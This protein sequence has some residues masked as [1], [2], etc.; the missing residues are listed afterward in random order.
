[1]LAIIDGDTLAYKSCPGRAKFNPN[2]ERIITLNEAGEK[3]E[4]YTEE[5]NAKY[6]SVVWDNFINGLGRMLSKCVAKDFVMAIKG[7]DNFRFKIYDDYKKHRTAKPSPNFPIVTI[8]RDLCVQHGMAI[9]AHG[10]EADDYIRIWANEARAA[11]Q[12]YI[13][14]TGDK[15]LRCIPGNH[16][17]ILNLQDF[18]IDEVSE[19]DAKRNYYAQLLSGDPTDWI[20]GLKGVADI[21]AR[22]MIADCRTEA[23]LQERVIAAYVTHYQ[24]DWANMLLTNGKL[25][26]IQNSFDDYFN[27][28]DWPLAQELLS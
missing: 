17:T 16:C 24:D 7:D 15:D 18:M 8:V 21:T 1:M 3:V 25:I 5:E 4:E 9:R 13:I 27:F 14:C 11:D 19:M 2:G 6:L 26:H 20:P 12:P 28:K 22:K 10:R 23:E